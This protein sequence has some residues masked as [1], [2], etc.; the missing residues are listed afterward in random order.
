MKK[1]WVLFSVGLMLLAAAHP[2][3][4]DVLGRKTM[5]RRYETS[6]FWC[7][8]PLSDHPDFGD[9]RIGPIS[10]LF[11]FAPISP[12]TTIVFESN[13]LKSYESAIDNVVVATG[14]VFY[15]Q[16]LWGEGGCFSD[17]PAFFDFTRLGSG[18]SDLFFADSFVD[19]PQTAW[20]G[21]SP[22]GAHWISQS[23]DLP[24]I[25]LS[26]GQ[27]DGGLSLNAENGPPTVATSLT[28]TN[29]VPGETYGLSFWWR[30]SI[31]DA[32]HPPVISVTAHDTPQLSNGLTQQDSIFGD[33]PLESW[34]Y[35]YIE[36][37]EDTPFLSF[38]LGNLDGDT[39]LY[40]R[41][42]ELPDTTNYDC[43]SIDWFDTDEHC[44]ISNPAPGRW[45]IGVANFNA[46]FTIDYELTAT[47]PES[48]GQDF[49]TLSS[50]R[51]LDTRTPFDRPLTSG[52]T[53]YVTFTGRCGVPYSA[54]AVA[55]NLT[56][57]NPTG[58]GNLKLWPGNAF[59]PLVSSVN[60]GPGATVANN[61]ILG[62]ATDGF[63]D[64]AVKPFVS[65]DGTVHLIVDVVG[66]FQ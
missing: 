51:I 13:N 49:Y 16:D 34:D 38:T 36:V 52:L 20:A 41:H 37:P 27:I 64:C 58:Q 32:G 65:G 45:W 35:F 57:T 40:I 43:R 30:V 59:E 9:P 8:I 11:L 25:P 24:P 4:A 47:W 26:Q 44:V 63:G 28:L 12:T 42:G 53:D 48:E 7:Q 2:L 39:D 17:I 66:Y 33:A 31:A 15:N 21:L 14:S 56:V 22:V 46:G 54:R 3:A 50:C 5:E 62:L 18:S 61:A 1:E 29:L 60:F 10:D 23:S 19:G 55:V 6:G